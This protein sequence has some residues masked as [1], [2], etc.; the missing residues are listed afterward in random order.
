MTNHGHD[1]PITTAAARGAGL[2]GNSKTAVSDWCRPPGN[3]EPAG[4]RYRCQPTKNGHPSVGQQNSH[5]VLFEKL[6]NG[7]P[8]CLYAWPDPLTLLSNFLTDYRF[9]SQ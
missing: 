2:R 9:L 4:A 3:A 7:N 6:K 5:H 1:S 8:P